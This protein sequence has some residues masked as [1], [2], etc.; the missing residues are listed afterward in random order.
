VFCDYAWPHLCDT[1]QV[2]AVYR[3]PLSSAAAE[4][5][6]DQPPSET[7]LKKLMDDDAY[8]LKDDTNWVTVLAFLPMCLLS[9]NTH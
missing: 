5:L 8:V 2:V 7:A 3:R 1:V 6:F 9:C 4:I